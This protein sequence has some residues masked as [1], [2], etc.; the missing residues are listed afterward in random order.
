MSYYAGRIPLTDQ[1]NRKEF[2]K[3]LGK[4]KVQ[5]SNRVCITMAPPLTSLSKVLILRN[6]GL[7]AVGNC[8][9]EC[10]HTM[11]NLIQ[12]CQIQVSTTQISLSRE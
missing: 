9:E 5:A 11:Y 12:A 2:A 7:V 4:N 3:A 1:S 10:F 8:V 6:H